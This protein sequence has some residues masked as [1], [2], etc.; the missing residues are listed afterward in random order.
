M[1]RLSLALGRTVSEL[2]QTL[3]SGELTE[4]KAYYSIEPFG[5][6]RDNWN[7]AMVAATVANY[8]GKVKIAKN[9]D[10]F[11]LIHPK[12]KKDKETKKTLLMMQAM[13]KKNG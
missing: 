7:T 9:I 1:F 10:D 11:M 5:Q 6:E 12:I 2:E 4:W 8:S 13:A 3:G